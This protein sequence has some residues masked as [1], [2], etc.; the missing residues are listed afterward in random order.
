ML[1]Q[2]AAAPIATTKTGRNTDRG[3]FARA[4]RR[5]QSKRSTSTPAGSRMTSHG[6]KTANVV[7]AITRGSV[8]E[9]QRGGRHRHEL[10]T[11]ADVWR[12]RWPSIGASRP[13]GAVGAEP[14]AIRQQIQA[15][16]HTEL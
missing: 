5:R 9:H 12:S 1:S 11:I 2:P 7:S 4:V 6:R 15:D 10:D 13:V 3:G 14:A 16:L 8:R